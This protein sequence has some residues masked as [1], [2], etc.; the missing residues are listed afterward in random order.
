MSD[1]YLKDPLSLFS[2]K[3]K[4]AIVTGASGAFGAMAA[5]VLAG[6]GA[7]VVISAGGAAALDKVTGRRCTFAF[8]PWNWERGDGCIVRLVAIVDPAQ[9]FR[10]DKGEK[11]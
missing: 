7:N 4:T 3:G 9:K 11:F 2:V 10:I 8:F 5:K 6:S 1:D